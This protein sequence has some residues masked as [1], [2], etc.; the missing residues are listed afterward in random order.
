MTKAELFSQAVER[1]EYD[2]R[3]FDGDS[4]A[5]YMSDM[6][7]WCIVHATKYMPL[8]KD[9][10]TMYVPST[11]MATKFR[12]PRSTVHTT[13]N[14]IVTAH[15]SGSWNDT[16]IVVLAPYN[17]I[18]KQNGDP[19]V[20]AVTDTFWSVDP[21]KG[22]VLP[23]S[24]CVVQ[25]DDNGPLWE[26]GENVATYK[27]D[28]YTDEEIKTI[29]ESLKKHDPILKRA[30][31]RYED[32]DFQDWEIEQEF[33]GDKR[34]KQM[35]DEA[36]DKKAFLHGLFEEE[37]FG[38][39]SRYLR[40]MV[41]RMAMDKLGYRYIYHISDGNEVSTTVESVGNKLGIVSFASNK[42]HSGSSFS[43]MESFW[44]SMMIIL[45]GN[46]FSDNYGVLNAPDMPKLYDLLTQ[47]KKDPLVL[48]IIHN[49]V[50]NK[51]IDFAKLYRDEYIE[52]TKQY[53]RNLEWRKRECE[54]ELSYIPGY[55]ISEDQKRV[56]REDYQN[57]IA[58]CDSDIATWSKHKT[59]ADYDKNLAETIRRH[60]EYLTAEYNKWRNEIAKN[61]EYENLV[62]R[63]REFVVQ[64]E[65]IQSRGYDDR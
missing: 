24:A 23:K 11:A 39:L 17:D 44:E 58:Q 64:M 60:C 50:D 12:I 62:Q 48:E 9:D 59:I 56:L 45:K 1:L 32:C 5:Y 6:A 16:P 35:Y 54:L 46:G 18:V 55:D 65:L 31:D 40:D 33:D 15:G 57:K 47:E 29:L 13:L 21:D 30:Y 3:Y 27:R 36:K 43:V 19:A 52:M 53:I 37:R 22:L 10:G 14:H 63:L 51:P 25:P 42:A 38:I 7:N 41:V 8:K 49:I 20:I 28:N 26:I 2:T 4:Q 61:P 34:I